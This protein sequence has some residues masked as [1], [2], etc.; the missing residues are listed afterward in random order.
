MLSLFLALTGTGALEVAISL[1]LS[2]T[3]FNVRHSR[4]LSRHL[5][6]GLVCLYCTSPVQAASANIRRQPRMSNAGESLFYEIVTKPENENQ[7]RR[8]R[9][10]G[11]KSQTFPPIEFV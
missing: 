9:T 5:I 1:F 10:A 3:K 4:I 8:K 6:F 2:I 7:E 11:R